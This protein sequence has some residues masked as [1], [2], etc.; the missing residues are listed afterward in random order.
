M[1]RKIF[2][3]N[4][5]VGSFSLP[6]LG[7]GT[8]KMGGVKRRDF[9]NDDKRDIRAI[10]TALKL[11]YTHID[12]AERY[13]G[14]HAE[15]LIGIAMK[16]FKREKI[17]I[18][19]KVYSNH[20]K[21]DAVIRAAKRSLERLGTSYID[22]YLIHHPNPKISLKQTMRA[23]DFLYEEGMIKHIGVS[24]FDTPLIQEAQ[25][26]T[27]YKIVNNQIN[28]NLS[29]R[30]Y[31]ENGTLD[32][33]KK[34][35]ILV[36]AYRPICHGAFAEGTFPL[37][38]EIAEK[39]KKSQA[40]I[41]IAWLVSKPNIVTIAKA[42]SKKYLKENIQAALLRLSRADIKKLDNEFPRGETMYLPQRRNKR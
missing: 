6:A 15:R 4:K 26:C 35:K 30:G 41:A 22:Q 37:L 12:T 27:K 2:V 42:T 7:L 18:T 36:T 9:D 28:Y 13:A 19:S 17:Y 24:N 38:A 25:S 20:L 5:K 23:M 16:K 39:Y 31:E 8:Y 29:A 33:C 40:Q 11:G 1:I 21:Y 14:G 3:P 32:Y 34:H 10:K